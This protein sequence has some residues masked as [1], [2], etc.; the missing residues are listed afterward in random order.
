MCIRDSFMQGAH[1]GTMQRAISIKDLDLLTNSLAT[2][3]DNLAFKKFN[4]EDEARDEQYRETR[5][6]LALRRNELLV[7][8]RILQNM[9]R[10]V[11]QGDY[12]K[13]LLQEIDSCTVVKREMNDVWTNDTLLQNYCHSCSSEFDRLKQLLL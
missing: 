7:E 3:N 11:V 4:E 2:E 1:K 6:E 8:L 5:Q 10:E 13:F 12:R 9:E